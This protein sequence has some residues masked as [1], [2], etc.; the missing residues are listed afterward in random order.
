M[1]TKCFPAWV[2]G[3]KPDTKVIVTGYS[4]TLTQQFSLEAKDIVT[5]QAYKNVF[6]RHKGIR[7]EQNTKEYWV[8]N[9]GGSYYAT[10][11][12]GSITGKGAGIF[13]IDDPIKPD[14]AESDIIRTGINN[15]FENTVP[16]RLDNP[17][18]GCII[19]I[20]QRTHEDDLCGHLIEKMKNHTGDDWTVLSM[21]AIAEKD[22]YIAVDDF[23]FTRLQ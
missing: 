18:K 1:I 7:E 9:D 11:T 6:P 4:S 23:V 5:S 21:P 14:E 22:E 19:I 12:G 2:L 16:S 13:I 3:N 20:M 10:G 17:N 8:L 15:W